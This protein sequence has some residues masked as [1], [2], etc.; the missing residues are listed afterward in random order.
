MGAAYSLERELGGGGMSRV[1]LA[2]EVRLRRKVVVKVLTPELAAGVSADRFEREIVLAAQLAHPSIVPVLTAG[3]ANGLPYYTMPFVDGESLRAR[4]SKQEQLSV[5]EVASILR[6][7]ARALAYA[8]ERGIVHRDIKP[9]NVLLASGAAVVTDFGIA[10][11][12]SAART[13]AGAATLTQAGTSI[14]TPAYMAPEQVIGDP[15]TDFAADLYSFGC[16]AYE[17]LT[18]ETPFHGRQ[19]H[20]L[21]A[22]HITEKPRDITSRR[23]DCPIGL[24]TLVMQCLEKEPDHRPS[25]ARE[26]VHR[27]ETAT[28]PSGERATSATTTSGR[29]KRP[30]WPFVIV[31]AALA[32]VVA[33]I[34]VQQ[35]M[36]PGG[37]ADPASA[38]PRSIAVLPF[39]NVGGDTADAYFAD[40][41]AE[42]LAT[43]LSKVAGLRVIARNSLFRSGGQPVDERAAGRAL[44]VDA[45]LSGTL[46]RAD[47][48]MR[49]TARLIKVSDG[50]LL[51]SEQYNRE[52][53]DVFGIQDEVA[54][55]IVTSLQVQLAGATRGPSA[56]GNRN[57]GT[58]NLEAH[59]LYLRGQF[60]LRRR[61]IPPAVDYF[62]RAIAL[63]SNYARAHSGLSASLEMLPYVGGVSADGVRER[64]M[65]EARRAL[66]LDS[67]LAEA[68][69]S[70]ALAYQHANQWNEAEVEHRRAVAIDPADGMVHLMYARLLAATGRIKAAV[71]EIRRAELLD[72][73]S[74]VIASWTTT[75]WLWSGKRDEGVAAAKRGLELDSMTAVMI[76]VAARS[77]LAAGQT[78]LAI[79]TADRLPK[80]LPWPGITAY[81]HA[82]SGDRETARRILRTVEARRTAWMAN[83]TIAYASL[84]LGDTTRALDALER[85]TDAREI[86]SNFFPLADPIYD[87]VRG[88]PRFAALARRVGLDVRSFEDTRERSQAR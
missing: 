87:G 29:L 67:T 11:A 73:F 43:R 12:I 32:L 45:L 72:P 69:T 28:T 86:W 79:A 58:T 10:K 62:E 55:A 16:L 9:E 42:E 82:M 37:E 7:I 13:D 75:T 52:V 1:F 84:G 33:G 35:R 14:G 6:D 65:A 5:G 66:S 85:A 41:I 68:H 25:S 88:S 18:G 48:R 70:M 81:V 2:E 20:K 36:K 40:G 47:T 23:P 60:N 76:Q 51:W 26:V 21:V 24:T 17:L 53:K 22:A 15:A 56:L 61:N 50:S 64:V 49:L 34:A 3:E 57:Q 4:L 77:Y 27:L 71:G 63:D 46:R 74:P 59:D 8:H 19:I 54:Q 38:A 83:M 78:E 44:A 30:A 39:T 80:V 31:G